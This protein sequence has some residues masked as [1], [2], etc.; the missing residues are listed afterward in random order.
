VRVKRYKAISSLQEFHNSKDK[1]RLLVGPFRSGKSVAAVVELYMLADYYSGHLRFPLTRTVVVRKTYRMLKDSVVKT[2]FEW[3]PKDAGKW[4]EADMQF[5][6]TLPSGGTWEVLF[7]SA[8]TAEDIEKFRGV[9]ITTFWIDEA[10]E[11]SQDVK[12]ILEGRCSFPA[13]AP[14][15]VFRSIITTNPSSTEHWIYRDFVA[16]PLTG[17]VY[18]RQGADE[19]PHLHSEY[20][21]E[22]EEL[23]RDRPE[24]L[25][26]YV[27]GEWG[28]IFAGKPVYVNEFNFDL[29]VSNGPITPVQGVT[30]HRGWDFGLTPAC[31]FTQVS[32]NGQWLVL[33]ELWS[34]DMGIDE[35]GDAASDY[36]KQ[37]FRGFQFEDVGDPAGKSRATTDEKTCME[38]LAGKGIHCREAPTNEFIPRRE[39]V[40]RKLTRTSKGHPQLLIDPRCKRLVDGFSGGYRYAER[41]NTGTF[42]E[43]PEKNQYSHTH[44]AL[45]YVALDL[46][47]YVDFNPR[48][49]A[50]PIRVPGVVNA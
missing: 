21:K 18:W 27:K 30:I 47:G 15:E 33:R 22:M 50:T 6:M 17:H 36:S 35:F 39:S 20:Y 32:P 24:I 19:N 41:G 26:R 42:S 34:D 25:R 4:S 37:N 43:R 11:V 7:R 38:I 1:S 40:A 48:D 9:E 12:L 14:K 13:G 49:W 10:Q 31:V 23:Y 28:A 29:H 16:N 8:D 44:D 5:T 3:V 45:Q 46:F 2:F